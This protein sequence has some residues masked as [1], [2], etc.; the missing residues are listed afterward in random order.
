MLNSISLLYALMRSYAGQLR[1]YAYALW[2]GRVADCHVPGVHV[3]LDPD[4]Q[5]LP[6]RVTHGGHFQ[7]DLSFSFPGS[8]DIFHPVRVYL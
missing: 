6:H 5:P 3:L 4:N 8:P 1:V 2:F 7:L